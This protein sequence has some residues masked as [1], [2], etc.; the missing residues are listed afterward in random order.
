MDWCPV[1]LHGLVYRWATWPGVQQ[2]RSVSNTGQYMHHR[3]KPPGTVWFG[4]LILPRKE[5]LPHCSL[6][7]IVAVA[8]ARTYKI[9]NDN[10]KELLCPEPLSL[11][12]DHMSVK[13]VNPSNQ[14]SVTSPHIIS[15][16]FFP[17]CSSSCHH[18]SNNYR[19]NTMTVSRVYIST[20]VIVT[21]QQFL[22][23]HFAALHFNITHQSLCAC[24]TMIKQPTPKFQNEIKW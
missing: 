23:V 6:W 15:P 16:T 3:H 12:A 2:H 4:F 14:C 17:T 13:S 10:D 7:C 5:Q 1:G 20:S 8:G 24:T 11:E 9:K 19:V 18:P 21:N 22:Q